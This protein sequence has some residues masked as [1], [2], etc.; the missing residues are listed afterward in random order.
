MERGAAKGN[1]GLHIA[2]ML[3]VKTEPQMEAAASPHSA[4]TMPSVIFLASPS[5]IIVLSR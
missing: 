1:P 4:L 3:Q 2:R 5:S